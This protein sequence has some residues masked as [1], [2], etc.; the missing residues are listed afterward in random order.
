M[1]V[2]SRNTATAAGWLRRLWIFDR[3]N[4]GRVIYKDLT[5]LS[6]IPKQESPLQV[7]F[8]VA[9]VTSSKRNWNGT[10]KEFRIEHQ[11]RYNNFEKEGTSASCL[12]H[13]YIVSV[14]GSDSALLALVFLYGSTITHGRP[15]NHVEHD[16]EQTNGSAKTFWPDEWRETRSTTTISPVTTT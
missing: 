5:T 13:W 16:T 11:R 12:S 3:L 10:R 6:S 4:F 2:P 9:Q 15:E 1:F 7:L 8:C 14:F